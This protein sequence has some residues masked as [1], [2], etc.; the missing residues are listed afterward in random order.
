MYM[1]ANH[2]LGSP[3]IRARSWNNCSS[4]DIIRVIRYVRTRHNIVFPTTL[5]RSKHYYTES[6][7]NHIN[8]QRRPES[9]SFIQNQYF[10]QHQ[11]YK[12]KTKEIVNIIYL[13][14]ENPFFSSTITHDC[15]LD[16]VDIILNYFVL[17]SHWLIINNYRLSLRL[18]SSRDLRRKFR[19]R[20]KLKFEFEFEKWVVQILLYESEY[21]GR[22]FYCPFVWERNPLEAQSLEINGH[23]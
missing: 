13:Y 18:F 1:L 6:L 4:F 16:R 21:I 22:H 3:Y 14:F 7:Q 20:I 17:N 23:L 12:K 2:L 8:P 11:L 9:C 19:C 10:W 5:F 15:Q